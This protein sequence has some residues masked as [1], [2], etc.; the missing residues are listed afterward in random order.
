[1]YAF[2]FRNVKSTLS[3]KIRKSNIYSVLLLIFSLP[4][5]CYPKLHDV[6]IYNV[7]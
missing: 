4:G 6:V 7:T 5:K 1:M 2:V 3:L